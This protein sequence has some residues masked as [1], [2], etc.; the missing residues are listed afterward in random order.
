MKK[1]E[2]F[3]KVLHLLKRFWKETIV[4]VV[5]ICAQL[6]FLAIG[7]FFSKILIDRA[8]PEKN[9][10]LLLTMA[11]L[12]FSFMAL[13]GLVNFINFNIYSGIN[14]KF[15]QALR[16]SVLN[17]FQKLP[18]H[19]FNS[20][21]SGELLSRVTYDIDNLNQLLVE[22]LLSIVKN[23]TL[24]LVIS[25]FMFYMNYKI[26]LCA[27]IAIPL[28]VLLVKRSG[29]KVFSISQASQEAQEALAGNIQENLSGMKTI[30]TYNRQNYYKKKIELEIENSEELK[31][32]SR[33]KSAMASLTG[34]YMLL[35]VTGIIWGIGGFDIIEGRLTIG[36]FFAL[37]TYFQFI[38][39]PINQ[40]FSSLIMMQN[41]LSSARRIFELFEI[42]TEQE[43]LNSLE[44]I[45]L[46]NGEIC[47]ADVWLD[48]ES[49]GN[50][51]KNIN[52]VINPGEVVALIGHSG[53][54][55]T[56][57]I[58][59]IMKFF[60]PT[61]GHVTIGG[62]DIRTI[63]GD[64]LRNHIALVSQDTYIFNSTI[65]DNIIMGNQ[66]ITERELNRVTSL[67]KLDSYINKMPQGMDT[68]VG[69]R[70]LQLSGGQ[71]KLIDL[72]RALLKKPKIL[73]LDEATS[74]L[75]SV[76]ESIIKEAIMKIK[77]E[78]T[79]IIISHRIAT[80]SWIKR[81]VVMKEG[82]IDEIGDH[83]VLL[84]N[85]EL[86]RQLYEK[87]TYDNYKGKTLIEAVL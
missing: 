19:F 81:I 29:E 69:E 66:A 16:S 70:G 14:K 2:V 63:K 38:T 28:F 24:I 3:K 45:E 58:N 74:E 86:Y 67:L 87:F 61:K 52:L 13:E 27:L 60:H 48:Y 36:T 65:R 25:G 78:M 20:K 53:V 84:E 75:D 34:N 31:R 57:L 51:L 18:L 6:A 62:Q 33:I 8:L 79:I 80:L 50:V 26:A 83:E 10:M 71:R 32:K 77:N 30:K 40:L 35:L 55:K 73:I 37:L 43:E 49:R 82:R 41:S 4:A 1:M 11:A 54:G 59:L 12:Y 39:E 47:F 68:R 23:I 44:D 76:S 42:K 21:K 85:N 22:N 72:C 15:Y 56:S 5:L 46:D 7:P 9:M 64:S 17:H